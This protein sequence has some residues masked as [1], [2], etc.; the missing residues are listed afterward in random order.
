MTSFVGCTV[1]TRGYLPYARVLA[2]SF[3]KH[4]RSADFVALLVD[5]DG[6][7]L[8]GEPFRVL[9]PAEIG[10]SL[11]ELA[12]RG[13]MYSATE[14]VCS[15]RPALLGH[16]LREG[17]SAA[18][19]M[20]ADGCVYGDLRAI[21][22]RA[23]AVGTLFTPHLL[24]PHDAP[25]IDDESLELVQIG[26]GVLNGG[27]IVAAERSTGFLEW[28]DA[29]L[30]RH[31]LN[32]PERGLYLD[33]RWLDLALGM[34]PAE[35]LQEPGCN[36]MCL[37]LQR[38]DVLWNENRPTMPEAPLLYFHFLLGFDPERPEQ[39]CNEVFAR[40]WLPYLD[41]RPGARRLAQEYAGRLLAHGAPQARRPPQHYDTLP[42]GQAVDRHV[43][44][45]YRR[46]VLEAERDSL[47]LPPNPFRD[48]DPDALLRWLSEPS[49]DPVRDA[50]LSRY[51]QAIRDLRPDLRSAF[52]E[53][54]GEHTQRFL[55][56][57]DSER[58]GE[59][60]ARYAIPALLDA[61]APFAARPQAASDPAFGVPQQAGPGAA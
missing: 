59:W 31:C 28:L 51:R 47:P 10:I 42:G 43:R 56:W 61:G 27:F 37:N 53:V 7:E 24:A 34:F 17:V 52:P 48:G 32:A 1:I 19:L 30:A 54:P 41:E 38:R 58:D 23:R 44:A 45:A 33:Q 39:I 46:G 18:I 29:R 25:G 26:Y 15:L 60:M 40:R 4:N 12:I 21:A 22:D 57:V 36:V 3:R 49:G 13:L 9:T 11:D 6:R 50:G 5:G 55:A 2:E 16:L 14:L 8:D 35:V 20:D